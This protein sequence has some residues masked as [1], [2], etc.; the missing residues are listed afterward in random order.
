MGCQAWGISGGEPML[1]PDFPEIFDYITRKAVTY[2]LNTNGTLITPEIAKLLTRKGTKMVALY[3]ATAEVHDLVTRTP[4]SFE[5]TMRGFAYLKEAGAAFVV[6]IIPMAAN[7]HQHREMLALAASLSPHCRI[8]SPWLFLSACGSRARNREIALQRLEP[9]AVLAL[10]PPDPASS[11]SHGS[12][13]AGDAPGAPE[14]AAGDGDDRLFAR[15]I[16][17]RREFHVDPYGQ[18]TFCGLIKDPDL[19]YDLRR[20]SFRQAW[21][22]FIPGLANRVRGGREY[23]ENCGAC[24]LRSDCRWC[25][26]YGY[27][28]HGRS[29]AK[30]DYLCQVAAETH[31]FKEEWKMTHLRH[32]AIAGITVRL[33]ADFPIQDDTFDRKFEKFR[34]SGP[35][36]DTITLQLSASMPAA[37]ELRLGQEV[38]HKAP[39]AIYRQGDS[40]TYLGIGPDDR[41]TQPHVLAVFD[42]RH[43]HGRIFRP[44]GFFDQ[45]NL[46]SL[47]TFASDQVLLARA[48]ADRE[49]CYLHAAGIIIN[50]KGLLF[51]GHSEAGKT[52]MLRM[53][54][55]HGEVLCDDRIIVRRWPDGFRIHGT[56]SHGELPDVSP[57]GAPL[58]AIMFLEKATVNE[59]VPVTKPSERMTRV[60]SHMIRPL[61]TV[62][63]W[64]KMLALTQKM[65]EEVPTYRLRFD[66]S[67][68][69]VSLL[70]AL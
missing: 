23:L 6:Q 31:R 10:D 68:G 21:E 17:G 5:E 59:L 14:R 30:V 44:S 56:W 27:L 64:E 49:G 32:Y 33:T 70:K 19:R 16:S 7:F 26:V 22:E 29:G 60:L 53:L 52:T 40:W 47:T 13:A 34:V 54:Q 4:G 25:G 43:N 11:L 8:G 58:R 65:A 48:L 37:S 9:A 63:W 2:S 1:R 38:Y 46:E 20:G 55:E 50:G 69:V 45:G 41:A 36:E 28:E 51:V 24:A 57:A 66:K 15:C 3:A 35:G 42:G 62:D 18:M 61:V 39:W 12:S 67:G